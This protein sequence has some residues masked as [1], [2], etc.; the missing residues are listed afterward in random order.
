LEDL[1]DQEGMEMDKS[2]A[3][4]DPSGVQ[5]Q[6]PEKDIED[7]EMDDA[8][9]AEL[10]DDAEQ[11]GGDDGEPEE[12]GEGEEKSGSP[13]DMEQDNITEDNKEGDIRGAEHVKDEEENF[14]SK[15]DN[16]EADNIEAMPDPAQ[17]MPMTDVNGFD[18]NMQPEAN[19]ANSNDLST[20]FAPGN[21]STKMEIS[22]PD[23][24]YG[25][26]LTSDSKLE[27][28]ERDAP[29]DRQI[30]QTNPF[31]S[32]GDAL[33]EWK[34]RAEVSADQD[35]ADAAPDDVSDMD[36]DEYMY[37]AEGQKSTSQALGAATSD[38]TKNDVDEANKPTTDESDVKKREEATRIDTVEKPEDLPSV[39]A[40]KSLVHTDEFSDGA[41]EKAADMDTPMEEAPAGNSNLQS[42]QDVVLFSRSYMD[43]NIAPPDESL[44]NGDH[45]S[46]EGRM[47]MSSDRDVQKAVV[48]WKKLELSTM[49]MSQELAEQLRLVLEPTLASKLQGDYRT[50][51]RINM[52]KVIK[53]LYIY[54]FLKIY[55]SGPF[56]VLVLVFL[57]LICVDLPGV[58]LLIRTWFY[59]DCCFSQILILFFFLKC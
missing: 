46:D 49:R 38:Q 27:A 54:F 42:N 3:F 34:E 31:R 6:E 41:V 51:K 16:K 8:E 5:F 13:N 36:A 40:C 19:W 9:D 18:P 58:H 44:I 1:K 47:E 28:S 22:M 35:Q 50:G 25:S 10:M 59:F 20:S 14:E 12:D 17:A 33:K 55:A 11:D 29:I 2:E 43:G 52:K 26:K 21:D 48:E 45:P 4:E 56:E 24:S 53:L 39:R 57:L 7:A 23:S 15:E 30:Q 37:V 32:I